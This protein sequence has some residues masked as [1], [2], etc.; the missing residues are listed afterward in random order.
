MNK[1]LTIHPDITFSEDDFD[2]ISNK[3]ISEYE[4]AE[5]NLKNLKL[6]RAVHILLK[7]KYAVISICILLILALFA[8]LGP[9]ISKYTYYEQLRGFENLSPSLSHPF[10]TDGLG[11]DIFV[12]AMYATRISILIG[13]VSSIIVLIIGTIYGAVSGYFA[14]AVDNVMMRIADLV[15]S[16]PD[17]IVVILLSIVLK[18][19]LYELFNNSSSAF[20]KSFALL[21]P[22]VIAIFAAFALLY[23]VTNARIIRANVLVLRE[24][25]YITAAKAIG[26]GRV[27][28]IRK[29]IIPNCASQMI[30][31]TCLMIPSAI[32]LESF[33]SFLGLGVSA[34]M[35]S[36]GS[37][38]NEAMDGVYSYTYRLIIPCIILCV[39]ILCLNV[40]GDKLRDAFDYGHKAII[41]EK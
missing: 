21:G 13:I 16:I 34:P 17:V 25:D 14:G 41:N 38:I 20:I 4:I 11:R 7:N 18:Q 1:I 26:C 32:F 22:G 2:K 12:R 6:S 15:Y 28:I 36:L 27:R 33:L 39:L 23:W 29:H 40:L 5:D 3:D 8:F 9:L 30:V 24:Q 37:M 31:T 10:G 35:T 19:P